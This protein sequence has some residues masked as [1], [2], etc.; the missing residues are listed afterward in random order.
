[1]VMFVKVWKYKTI[2]TIYDYIYQDSVA[3]KSAPVGDTPTTPRKGSN[4]LASPSKSMERSQS[5]EEQK[6]AKIKPP[7]LNNITSE[8]TSTMSPPPAKK[9]ALSAKKVNFILIHNSS[10]TSLNASSWYPFPVAPLHVDIL[11]LTINFNM[12]FY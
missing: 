5:T 3:P 4:G 1:M 6:T 11:K 8:L 2:T 9:L 7:A 10:T 12:Y